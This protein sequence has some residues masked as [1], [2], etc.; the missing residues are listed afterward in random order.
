MFPRFL[1][2]GVVLASVAAPAFAQ[3]G[4]PGPEFGRAGA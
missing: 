4:P 3:D 1:A 2:A